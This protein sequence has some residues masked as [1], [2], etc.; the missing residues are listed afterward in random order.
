MN[1]I[2]NHPARDTPAPEPGDGVRWE[3]TAYNVFAGGIW[4]GTVTSP[5]RGVW[6]ADSVFVSPRS[7]VWSEAYRS[8]EAA[9][10]A[11]VTAWRQRG[12]QG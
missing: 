9:R 10:D 2:D 4:L 6:Q 1:E 3:A 12:Q 11:L 8:P 7:I 5:A